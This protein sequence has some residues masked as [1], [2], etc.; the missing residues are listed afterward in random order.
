MSVDNPDGLDVDLKFNKERLTEFLQEVVN[1]FKKL[2]DK[3][4]AYSLKMRIEEV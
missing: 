4:K 1:S 2:P 3:K